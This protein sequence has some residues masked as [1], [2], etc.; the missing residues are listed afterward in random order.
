MSRMNAVRAMVL[1]LAACASAQNAP[2]TA[3]PRASQTAQPK[4]FV[5]PATRV[6]V[7]AMQRHAAPALPRPELQQIPAP[8]SS[9]VSPKPRPE[10]ELT[11]PPAAPATAHGTGEM[12]VDFRNG[13]LSVIADDAELGKVLQ[14]IGD[15]TGASVEVAPEV[16]GERVMA[17]LGPGP[18]TE[19]VSTLLSSPRLDFILMGSEDQNSIKRLIVRRKASFGKEVVQ[20]RPAPLP[21]SEPE[22]SATEP[23][24]EAAADQLASEPQRETPPR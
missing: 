15:K 14:Q 22:P 16:A 24:A 2:T 5:P 6:P 11:V 10:P 4:V 12:T 19:I 9:V 23:Q 20:S 18:A 13:Q 21:I 7:A 8:V 1:M 17:R 3:A